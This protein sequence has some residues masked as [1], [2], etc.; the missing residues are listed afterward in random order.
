M[1][2]SFYGARKQDSSEMKNGDFSRGCRSQVE[3]LPVDK[4]EKYE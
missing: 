4:S 1:P 3:E 2:G